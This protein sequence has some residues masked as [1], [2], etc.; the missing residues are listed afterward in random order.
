MTK[1][2]YCCIKKIFSINAIFL[3]LGLHE[4]LSRRTFSTSKNMSHV[5]VS[6]LR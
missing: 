4:G 5:Y 1:K 3:F 2:Y 6:A